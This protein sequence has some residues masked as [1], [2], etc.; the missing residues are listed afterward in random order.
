LQVS[1]DTKMALYRIAQEA[2]NN[3]VKHARAGQVRITLQW[4]AGRG[5]LSVEDDGRGFDPRYVGSEKMGLQIMRERA[6][7]IGGEL[8]VTSAPGQGTSVT[9]TWMVEASDA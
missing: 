2:I 3:V 5:V 9:V 4:E 8:R 6:Q 1:V 7:A